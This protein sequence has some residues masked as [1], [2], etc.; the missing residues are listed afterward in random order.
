[1]TYITILRHQSLGHMW[2]G[3]AGTQL[4]NGSPL[5]LRKRFGT[6]NS[7]LPIER[8]SRSVAIAV[9]RATSRPETE[10]VVDIENASPRTLF[11]TGTMDSTTTGATN[12]F[13]REPL[14]SEKL[15]VFIRHGF[16]TWNEQRRIQAITKLA[17]SQ[18]M[19]AQ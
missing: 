8:C 14:I 3:V 10:L 15:V 12:A 16:S 7:A 9:P 2:T 19:E 4:E 13:S 1:M 5:G 17:Y 18:S 6:I 11:E